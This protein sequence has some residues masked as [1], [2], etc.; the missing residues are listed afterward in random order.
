MLVTGCL[1]LGPN[2]TNH[3]VNQMLTNI[4]SGRV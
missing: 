1:D 3:D 4:Y 2:A